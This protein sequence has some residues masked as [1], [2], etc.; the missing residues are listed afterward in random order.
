LSRSI[1]MWCMCPRMIRGW[2]TDIRSWRGRAGIH[3]L[4]SGSVDLISHLELALE[5]GG[6]AALDGVG[7]TG[8]STGITTTPCLTAG[9]TTP[10]AGRFI[11]GVPML[12]EWHGAM[13]STATVEGPDHSME[14]GRRLGDTQHHTARVECDR[15]RSAAMTA[16][17]RPAAFRRGDSPALVVAD[18]MAAEEEG[19]TEA[20]AAVDGNRTRGGFPV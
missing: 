6:G 7:A 1:L 20:E 2:F 8:G 16:V 9:G 12:A 11:T 17:D 3:I 10:G 4:E 19:S 13:V 14:T 15:G 5:S 18:F